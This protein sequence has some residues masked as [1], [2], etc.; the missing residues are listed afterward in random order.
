MRP[1]RP[2]LGSI[3][4]VLI[5]SVYLLALTNDTFWRK[6][7][8]YLGGHEGQL[9]ALGFC[10]LL[11]CVAAL[12]TFSAKYIVKPF[13]IFAILVAATASYFVDTFGLVIDREMIQ[14]VALTTSSEAAH[15]LSPGLLAHLLAYGIL[16][17][18]LVALVK[19]AHR[20]FWEKVRVNSLVIFPC[21]GVTVAIVL[22]NYPS[23]SSTFRSHRDLMASFNPA[24]PIVA[25]VK[26]AIREMEE[27][28]IVA[29]PLG[30]DARPA[31]RAGGTGK[32]LVTVVVVGETAR[33]ANFG[34][35]GYARDTNPELSRRDVVAFQNVASCGTSTAVSV[36]CMFSNLTRGGYSSKAGRSV[37]N[38]T[39]VL[40]HAHVDVRWLDN[41]TGS[42]DVADRIPYEYLPA[43]KDPRFCSDGECH[44]EI[45][46]EHLRTA[47]ADVRQDTVIFLHQLGSHG[48][49]YHL[50]APAAFQ[51]YQPTCRDE[52]FA[53]CTREEIVNAY[54]N[55]I[56]YTDHVLAEIVDLLAD[57]TD[58]A[59]S[60]LYVSD[61]GESLGENGLYL[62]AIPYFM[63]P[64][65]QTHV[66]M[67]AWFSEP[68]RRE[69]GIDAACVA[70]RKDDPLSHDNFFHTVLG[71]AEIATSVY[72]RGLDALAPCRSATPQLAAARETA[73]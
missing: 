26:Y 73:R 28:D 29:A 23:F 58:L 66:P 62:H 2:R 12:T 19:V 48:P 20:P 17:S 38:L 54:D 63:A 1:Y 30:T 52:S 69:T 16:P 15:L 40:S 6:G 47:L 5:V 46:V 50:R 39:D 44:D 42:A 36:P 8:A 10:L 43:T 35:Y 9:A 25:T 65:T 57:R 37:E 60:M 32:P 18:L 31:A 14:N 49:A 67:I 59:A 55:T 70:A 22:A 11:L 71:T 45:L 68:Y 51:R 33:A 34:L 64:S 41:N 53:D 13:L 72:D 4:L 56:L 3:P 7:L 21:L 24:A 27:R 61:H